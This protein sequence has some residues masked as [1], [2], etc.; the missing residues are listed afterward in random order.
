MP[1]NTKNSRY[2]RSLPEPNNSS[3]FHLLLEKRGDGAAVQLIIPVSETSTI[4][5]ESNREVEH[6][7]GNALI[8]CS[9]F[10]FEIL[11][12]CH[13]QALVA[14][15]SVNQPNSLPTSSSTASPQPAN[16]SPPYEQSRPTDPRTVP[17]QN[18][19][20]P[21][22]QNTSATEPPPGPFLKGEACWGQPIIVAPSSW[23][24]ANS[25]ILPKP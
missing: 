7:E 6:H 25:K 14:Q 12:C 13:G 10:W 1:R 2:G 18:G 16:F 17:V 19:Q 5:G 20:S 4:R 8:K 15:S 24:P 23:L 21:V 3:N 22:D 9:N 11:P